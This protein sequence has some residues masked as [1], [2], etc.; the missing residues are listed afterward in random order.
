MEISETTRAS[1]RAIKQSLPAMMNGV[2]AKS[3]RDKGI[4]YRVNYG[5]E[6]PRLQAFATEW[7]REA[8]LATALWKEDIRECRLLATM[9]M[10]Q[11]RFTEEMGNDWTAQVRFPEEAD[12]LVFHLL[13]HTSWAADAAFRWIA[14][15][16][17]TERYV[18]FQ[19]LTRKLSEGALL[20]TRDAHEFLDQA[21]SQ[22]QAGPVFLQRA[23]WRAVER[24]ADQG[25]AQERMAMPVLRQCEG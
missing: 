1:L 11:E 16:S 18:G 15:A 3:M 5:V 4:T 21:R 10:P 25:L 13:R 12:M 7:P 23:A 14:S 17:E 8:E 6:L 24:F 9:L 22:M 19:V 20:A 2:A